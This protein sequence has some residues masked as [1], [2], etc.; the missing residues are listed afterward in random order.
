MLPP[1]VGIAV[2]V[3]DVPAQT[4]FA[5]GETV[6]LTGSNGFTVIVTVFDVAGFPDG[7]V[8]LEVSTQVIASLLTGMYEYV[9]LLVP[10]FTPFTFHW[11]EGA[12]PPFVGVAVN[13]TDVPAQTG[14]AEGETE[15]LTGRIGF[16]VIVIVFDVAGLPVTQL[17]FE[18][19]IQMTVFPFVKVD[20]V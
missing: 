3:T 11:Y 15:T 5:E 19:R 13:V 18:V 7:Q 10:A 17:A 14:F 8:A 2:K 16:T 1:F 6:T 20:V 4:G 12:A 9:L